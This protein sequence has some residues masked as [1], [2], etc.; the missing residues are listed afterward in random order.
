MSIVSRSQNNR[1]LGGGSW[2]HRSKEVTELRK[3]GQ[4]DAAYALSA[5]RI[6][7]SGADDYDRAA[8]AWCLI[9]LVKQHSADGNIQKLS[10]YLD[11]LRRFE[12]PTSDEMLAEHREKALA[13]AD[14]ARRALQSARNLSK[15]GKHD[16]AA[17]IYSD[18]HANGKLELD[19]RKAWGWEIY[20]LN[21]GELGP[22]DV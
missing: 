15:Q 3:G 18:I 19:D 5:E 7:D 12:V 21:K 13:L 9:A 16:E 11:Q 14:P 22:V 6:A 2:N 10:D 20:R 8:Y 1:G 17:R 4:L